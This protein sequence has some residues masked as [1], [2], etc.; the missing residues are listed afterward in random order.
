MPTVSAINW[1]TGQTRA[2]NAIIPLSAVGQVAV[3][4]QGS[5]VVDVILDVNGF[6]E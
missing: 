2:N 5:G 1:S 4:A 6:F 3:R